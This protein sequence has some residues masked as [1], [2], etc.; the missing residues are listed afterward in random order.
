LRRGWLSQQDQPTFEAFLQPLTHLEWPIL[1]VLSDKQTGLVPAVA[2]VCPH[3]RYQFCQAHYRRNL[4][5]PLAEADAAFKGALRNTVRQQV[6]DLIRQEPRTM[7]GQAGIV[8]V[9]GL[10]PSLLEKPTAPAAQ[11]SPLRDT[12]TAPESTAN[13]IIAPLFRHPRSLRTLKGR[14]PFRLAGM[15]TYERLQNVA[16]CS[17]DL[18]AERYD[19]RLA[20]LSQGLQS[21]LAPF[22]QPYQACQQGAAWLRDIA[23]ILVVGFTINCRVFLPR[24]LRYTVGGCWM[25]TQTFFVP[26][27]SLCAVLHRSTTPTFRLTFWNTRAGLDASALVATTS[28][29]VPPGCCSCTTIPWR[30]TARQRP[31]SMCIPTPYGSGDAVGPAVIVRSTMRLAGAPSPVFPPQDHAVVK[32]I[33]WA[34]VHETKGPLSR[35]SLAEVTARARLAVGKPLSRSTVWRLRDADAIT[36]WP[37]PSWIL[38]RAP[39]FAP[40][41]GGMRD[42]DA[43]QGHG[44][45]LGANDDS[46]SAEEKTSIQARIRGHPSLRPAPGRTRRVEHADDRGGA[47]PY[48]AA[49]DVPRGFV[50]GRCAPWTGM[51]PCGRRVTP[52]M[53]QEPA[54]SAERVFWGVD[55]GSTHR[56]QAAVRRLV[57][58][59]A[60][61][62]VVHTPIHARWLNQGDISCAIVQRK[63][64]TPND[65]RRVEAVEHRLR[66]SEA[67]S[68]QQPHPFVWTFTRA[69]LAACLKRLEAHRA[70]TDQGQAVPGFPDM[71]QEESFAA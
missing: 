42:L 24:P 40:K 45:P 2:T 10:V 5:E 65:F 15:E 18:L 34:V 29:N 7:P 70:I 44:A 14:P 63:V 22:A 11:S 71:D 19:Q 6:G 26:G 4:A 12:L 35:Q 30:P 39:Q 68:N 13:E 23:Y 59:Y 38:P 49:W 33:A 28:G 52:V 62:I 66:L 51:V 46:L 69:K 16:Q 9:T 32:A 50:M 54:R 41:A 67:L 21:A 8:T 55:N 43:G 53:T 60:N 1:A 48:L 37:Y 57:K 56:G 27:G 64:R 25:D 17:L 61:T 31:R 20:H 36:P 3:S 58:A 47:L